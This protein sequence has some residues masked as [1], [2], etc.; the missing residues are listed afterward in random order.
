MDVVLA[1]EDPCCSRRCLELDL[2]L[3]QPEEDVCALETC[4][5]PASA[6]TIEMAAIAMAALRARAV[7]EP[8]LAVDA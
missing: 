2:G 3:A 6:Q 5:L 1:A 4:D 8:R 7:A